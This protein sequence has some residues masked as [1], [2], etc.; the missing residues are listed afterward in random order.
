M[1]VVAIGSLLCKVA[2]ENS[3]LRRLKDYCRSLIDFYKWFVANENSILR[4]LKDWN[5]TTY[6]DPSDAWVANENSILRRLKVI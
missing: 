3:I 2:N 6:S 5:T 4:R 1:L